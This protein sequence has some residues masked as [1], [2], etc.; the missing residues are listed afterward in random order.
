MN[1]KAQY[2]PVEARYDD[3]IDLRELVSTLWAGKWVIVVMT[4]V[5]ALAG[6]AYALSKPNL[7][8]AEAIL[9]PVDSDGNNGLAAMAGQLGGLASLAG[10]NLGSTGGTKSGIALEVLKSRAF[11]SDFIERHDLAPA[12][13]GTLGW[14]HATSQWI[15][16]PDLYDVRT[17]EW[18]LDGAGVSTEPTQWDLV[19]RLRE[20]LRVRDSK[21][22]GIVTVSI[23]SSSPLNARQ[24]VTWLVADLNMHVRDQD[25]AE[26]EARVA[27]LESQLAKTGNTGLQEV[28][29]EL[30]ESEM[31]T[32]MLANAQS[33]YVF[34]IIDPAVVPQEKSDPK[35]ALIAVI[36]VLLGGMLGVV[37]VFVRAFTRSVKQAGE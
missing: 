17:G 13:I 10:V 28:F 31:R 15:Y 4:A 26:S 24:W 11:L 30:I 1:Q 34:R 14:D 3:E 36:G 35:R 12:L 19:K 5:C 20:Q 6:I 2:L 16:D 18:Q 33:E 29:Y 9:A 23:R 27:Y 22:T 32:A 37:M 8:T 7:Y 21:D 25:I